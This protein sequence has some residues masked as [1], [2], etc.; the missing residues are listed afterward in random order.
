MKTPYLLPPTKIS[1]FFCYFPKNFTNMLYQIA[2]RDPQ[3][4]KNFLRLPKLFSPHPLPLPTQEQLPRPVHS[5]K[6]SVSKMWYL[7]LSYN[8]S[9]NLFQMCN[10]GAVKSFKKR[11]EMLVFLCWASL[12]CFT[13]LQLIFVTLKV[14]FLYFCKEIL[15][16]NLKRYFFIFVNI[17]T[18]Y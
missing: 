11:T 6:I 8:F 5:I 18:L 3:I 4:L 13:Y 7:S 15:R 17:P 10:L 14:K 2:S 16:N 9:D 1:T 12:P